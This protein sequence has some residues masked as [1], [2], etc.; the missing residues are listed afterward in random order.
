MLILFLPLLINHVHVQEG[1]GGL[2]NLALPGFT[3][4][5]E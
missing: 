4:L 5:A 3:K 1:G 2:V